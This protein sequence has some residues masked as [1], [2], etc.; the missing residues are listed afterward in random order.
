MS[1]SI[2]SKTAI[3]LATALT[4]ATAVMQTGR[5]SGT[6]KLKQQQKSQSASTVTPTKYQQQ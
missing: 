6:K 2:G 1:E 5:I 4:L 3:V